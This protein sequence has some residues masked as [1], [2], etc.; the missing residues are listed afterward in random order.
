MRKPWVAAL[1]A[2]LSVAPFAVAPAAGAPVAASA[3]AALAPTPPMG[4]NDWNAFGCKVDEQLVE[5][6]ADAIVD[7]GLKAAGYQYVNIDDCWMSGERGADGSLVPDPVKFPHG[8]AAVADYVHA[9]GLKLGIYESAGT[10]TCAHFPG[11]LGHER[12]DADSFASWGVDYLKYDSCPGNQPMPARQRYEA[13]GEALARTGRPIVYSLC[14]WGDQDVASWGG[15]VGQLWRTTPDIDPSFQR[16]LDIF[17]VN[18]QLADHARPGAWNDPD[19]LEVG[20][21]MTADEERAHFSLWA[22][23]A[24]PLLAGTDLRTA[25]PHTLAVLGNTE[26]IAVDQDPL[27]RQG[28]PVGPLGGLDVLAKPLGDGSVAV[29]L[30]NEGAERA[31]VSTTASAVGLPAAGSYV[32]RDLWEHT[33]GETSGT[34]SAEVPAHGA[35]MF[36]VAP[37][38]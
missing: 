12:Q 2:V 1:A 20:N 37:A 29:T 19:A 30:F 24:A 9:R 15:E 26:V 22:A 31:V 17:H 6:S 21:G 7:T 35:A 38:G 25:T 36:R 5:Q 13:M 4:W 11:S 16:M 33:T 32:V 27:G 28:R 23:M 14:N 18:A 34:I 3:G 10:E 8:I